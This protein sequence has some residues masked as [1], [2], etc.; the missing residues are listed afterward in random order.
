MRDVTDKLAA[1]GA[2]IPDEDQVVTL[3][4]SLPRSFVTIVTAIETRMDGVSLDYVQQALRQK[5][6]S[7]PSYQVS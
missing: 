2:P 4:G 6:L 5:K 7:N 3:L 1:I